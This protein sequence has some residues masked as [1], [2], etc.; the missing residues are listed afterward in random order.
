MSTTDAVNRSIQAGRWPSLVCRSWLALL[1][2]CLATFVPLR[3]AM[4]VDIVTQWTLLADAYGQGGANFRTTAIMH[5]AMHDALNAA[6]PTYA[7]WSPGTPNEPAADG[8]MPRA[9]MY[10]AARRV[11]LGLHPDRKIATARAY[12]QALG[13]ETPGP[14]R[15]A[16]VRLG[17]AIGT[18]A[19]ARRLYDGYDDTRPFVFGST[20]GAWTFTPEAYRGSNTTKM[21]P[22]LFESVHSFDAPPPPALDSDRYRRDLEETRRIGA[23]D[24]SERT[25]AQSEAAFF[26]AFQSSQRGY[27]A[28]AIRL[29]DEHPRP[30]REF[31]HARIMSQVSTALADSAVLAWAEKERFGFWRPVT[32]IRTGSPGVT[33]DTSWLP[34]METPAFP[35][36]PSG[37]AA[38]CYTGAMV[39]QGAFGEDVGAITYASQSGDLPDFLLAI[40]MGQHFQPSGKGIPADRSF[41]SLLASAEEC[42]ESRLWA[43][44]HFRFGADEARRLGSV[45]SAAAMAAVPPLK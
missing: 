33:V 19:L 20:P 43:G 5:Q 15:D 35:E 39:L 6:Q 27:I 17:E 14:A 37:H 23:S 12:F 45:I 28:L 11:L 22:F 26:W 44:A 29:L 9:A 16:G 31:E 42:A 36:Y 40:G 10:A 41:P 18:A 3:P 21:R 34:L 30:G 13:R 32:A 1:F 7:R 24:S 38:D 2:L 25:Q 4:A 8:A